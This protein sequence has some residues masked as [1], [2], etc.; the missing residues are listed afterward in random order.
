MERGGLQ[1]G[2]EPLP[3][4]WGSE[5]AQG[6]AFTCHITPWVVPGASLECRVHGQPVLPAL[7]LTPQRWPHW[8]A[9]TNLSF[10]RAPAEHHQPPP[11]L[12][13]D[14]ELCP[15]SV[16]PTLLIAMDAFWTSPSAAPTQSTSHPFSRATIYKERSPHLERSF[17]LLRGGQYCFSKHIFFIGDQ[18][19]RPCQKLC[20]SVFCHL[21]AHCIIICQLHW[22]LFHASFGRN[23]KKPP[24]RQ[25][26]NPAHQT[27]ATLASYCSTFSTDFVLPSQ[28][29][30]RCLSMLC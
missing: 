27:C 10:P 21:P 4:G 22:Q 20:I 26:D 9:L 8:R 25:S 18:F 14:T 12:A 11:A 2:G 1:G 7:E 28:M 13:K 19:T 29:S 3:V 24:G 16:F 30:C 5:A 17:L 23:I 6:A 15:L